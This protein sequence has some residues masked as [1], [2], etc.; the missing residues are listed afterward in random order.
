MSGF[1]HSHAAVGG[2]GAAYVSTAAAGAGPTPLTATTKRDASIANE[3]LTAA[4]AAGTKKTCFLWAVASR[5]VVSG[6]RVFD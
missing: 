2:T 5:P 4:A 6:S 3:F 1:V